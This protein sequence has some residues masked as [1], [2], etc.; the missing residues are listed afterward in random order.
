MGNIGKGS[1]SLSQFFSM[2]EERCRNETK[3]ENRKMAEL[4]GQ[5][6]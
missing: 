3:N 5:L 4:F 6:I 2:Q 1:F